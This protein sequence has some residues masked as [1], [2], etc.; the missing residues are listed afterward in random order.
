MSNEVMRMICANEVCNAQCDA[1][2]PCRQ[3]LAAWRAPNWQSEPYRGD[4]PL[5]RGGVRPTRL[6]QPVGLIPV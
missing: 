1:L 6:Y 3:A 5:E 2:A 4:S